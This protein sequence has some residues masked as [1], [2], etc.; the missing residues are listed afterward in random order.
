MN[1]E[2]RLQNFLKSNGGQPIGCLAERN[3]TTHMFDAV[4][5]NFK[6]VQTGKSLPKGT[7]VKLWNKTFV[8][9]P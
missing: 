7:R 8:T 4:T 2:K 1:T 9:V 6:S 3:P 5:A